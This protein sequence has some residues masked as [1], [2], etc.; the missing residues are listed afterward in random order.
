MPLQGHGPMVTLGVSTH[1]FS[2]ID[3]LGVGK[4][5]SGRTGH[6]GDCCRNLRDPESLRVENCTCRNLRVEFVHFVNLVLLFVFYW[7]IMDC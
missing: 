2:K 1:R 7:Y 3:G 5:R 4:L 6:S